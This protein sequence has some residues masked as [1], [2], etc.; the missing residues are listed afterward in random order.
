MG[1]HTLAPLAPTSR[2][3]EVERW[4]TKQSL[5]DPKVVIVFIANSANDRRSNKRVGGK[6]EHVGFWKGH[7][8]ASYALAN[9]YT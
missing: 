8:V 5:D 9:L 4:P 3:S 2:T 6:V 7:G 1:I